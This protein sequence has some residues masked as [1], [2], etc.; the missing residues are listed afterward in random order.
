MYLLVP[1]EI[2]P[3]SSLIA[4][5]T[6][7]RSIYFVHICF[8]GSNNILLFFLFL[9]FLML[10]FISELAETSHQKSSPD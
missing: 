10:E 4:F 2:N 1:S 8:L 7:C 3:P 6:L 5:I 9:F